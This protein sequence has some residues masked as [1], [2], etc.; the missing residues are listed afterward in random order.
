MPIL[1]SCLI[2]FYPALMPRVPTAGK[3]ER[4][5]SE[6]VPLL[7]A[8]AKDPVTGKVKK[9][10]P[11]G[12]FADL[13]WAQQRVAEQWLYKFCARWGSDLP[14]WRRGILTGVAKRLAVK[15]FTSADGHSVMNAKCGYGTARKYRELGLPHPIYN[16]R[17]MRTWKRAGRPPLPSRQLNIYS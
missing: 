10:N 12:P 3:V 14:P 4:Y 17:A 2:F 15:P 11:A 5:S 1:T 8:A 16:A 9:R 6:R 7:K 13:T